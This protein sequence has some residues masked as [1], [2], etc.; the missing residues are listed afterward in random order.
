MGARTSTS[1]ASDPTR[2]GHDAMAEEVFLKLG[3]TS[4]HINKLYKAFC[5]VDKNRSNY[6]QPSQIC[7]VFKLEEDTKFIEHMMAPYDA[8]NKGKVDF[9]EFVYGMWNFLTMDASLI[10]SY[11]FNLFNVIGSACLVNIKELIECIH[12]KKYENDKGVRQLVETVRDINPNMSVLQFAVFADKTPEVKEPLLALQANMR[13]H[14]VGGLF[15]SMLASRRQRNSE[16]NSLAFVS[17]LW[18]FMGGKYEY[19]RKLA[20]E[21]AL[22]R[23]RSLKAREN[24]SLR[25]NSRNLLVASNLDFHNKSQKFRAESSQDRMGSYLMKSLSPVSA[26][27]ASS[28]CE[29]GCGTHESLDD[30]Y[31]SCSATTGATDSGGAVTT[32]ASTSTSAPLKRISS[33]RLMGSSVKTSSKKRRKSSSAVRSSSR[34]EDIPNRDDAGRTPRKGRSMGNIDDSRET[35]QEQS[36]AM[37][38]GGII[39]LEPLSSLLSSAPSGSHNKKSRKSSRKSPYFASKSNKISPT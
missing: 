16:Q 14:I 17:D 22:E 29:E 20:E 1:F 12:H 23:S 33:E 30:A 11:A 36:G 37:A 10:A 25:G 31:N 6:V 15:W 26:K 2:P 24:R 5:D 32:P 39:K 8:G 38:A 27:V 9:L 21:T 28:G 34:R 19:I 4:S 35:W 18:S 7:S 13:K 3:L